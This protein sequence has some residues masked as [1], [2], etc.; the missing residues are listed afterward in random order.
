MDENLI[1][2]QI[3]LITFGKILSKNNPV[4]QENPV[5]Q[6]KCLPKLTILVIIHP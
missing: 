1:H 5:N 2:N 6:G 3:T 4:N